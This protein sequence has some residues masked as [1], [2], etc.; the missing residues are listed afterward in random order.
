M[1]CAD[2]CGSLLTAWDSKIRSTVGYWFG[3]HNSPTDRF[4]MPWRDGRFS[5]QSLRGGQN[6]VVIRTVLEMMTS[7]DEITGKLMKQCEKEE[8]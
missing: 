4:Q 5:F 3:I 7:D 8:A 6:T 2:L 1:M